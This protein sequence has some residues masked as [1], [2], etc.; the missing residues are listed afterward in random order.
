MTG[1]LHLHL[2]NQSFNQSIN[3]SI[4]KPTNQPFFQNDSFKATMEELVNFGIIVGHLIQKGFKRVLSSP[5]QT[6][7][8]THRPSQQFNARVMQEIMLG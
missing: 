4:N 5:P 2:I 3:Q 1:A 6:V 7:K 8:V